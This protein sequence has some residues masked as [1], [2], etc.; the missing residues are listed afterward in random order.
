MLLG[1]AEFNAIVI[2]MKECGC[3]TELLC[4]GHDTFPHLRRRQNVAEFQRYVA[5]FGARY[6]HCCVRHLQHDRLLCE[7]ARIRV[8][9][10]KNGAIPVIAAAQPQ[11][12]TRLANAVFIVSIMAIII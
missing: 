5:L 9:G 11:L 1:G 3:Q 4:V 7:I 6:T 8:L 10:L 12:I 2:F